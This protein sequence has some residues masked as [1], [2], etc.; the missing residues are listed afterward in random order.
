MSLIYSNIFSYPLYKR[1]NPQLRIFLPNFWLKLIRTTEPQP[2][3][4]VQFMVSMEMTTHDIKNYL[5]KIYKIPVMCVSTRIQ[6]G[7]YLSIFFL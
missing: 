4:I 5:E 2:P 6:M 3:N 1:G 7:K